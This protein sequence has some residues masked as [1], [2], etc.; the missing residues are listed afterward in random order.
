MP[1]EIKEL[2]IKAKVSESG[3]S[4]ANEHEGVGSR[5]GAGDADSVEAIVQACVRQVLAILARDAER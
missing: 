3:T 1:I 4:T 2:I 5:I